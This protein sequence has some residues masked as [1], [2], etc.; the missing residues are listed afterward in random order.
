MSVYDKLSS[1]WFIEMLQ[2]YA[3]FETKLDTLGVDV[4]YLTLVEQIRDLREKVE[5]NQEE[6]LCFCS[7]AMISCVFLCG[8][9]LTDVV[10]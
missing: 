2:D 6:I 10:E 7:R 4:Y 1:P 5:D 3:M 8:D 9:K